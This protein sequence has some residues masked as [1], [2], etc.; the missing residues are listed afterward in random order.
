M[1][2]SDCHIDN[3]NAVI[4]AC[5]VLHNCS[6]GNDEECDGVD[7]AVDEENVK[8]PRQTPQEMHRVQISQICRDIFGSC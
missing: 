3:M 8:T 1:K 6:E 7:V 2:R 4:A 5:R